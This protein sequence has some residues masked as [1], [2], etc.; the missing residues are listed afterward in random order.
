MAHHST[1]F[2]GIAS[3]LTNDLGCCCGGNSLISF[4][5]C[6]IY[7]KCDSTVVRCEVRRRGTELQPVNV[8]MSTKLED[9]IFI[10]TNPWGGTWELW[11]SCSPR[12]RMTLA[13]STFVVGYD[14]CP[15]CCSENPNAPRSVSFEIFS[16]GEEYGWPF[17]A[18]SRY[19]GT[20]IIPPNI[21]GCAGSFVI[22]N[23][24]PSLWQLCQSLGANCENQGV[25]GSVWLWINGPHAGD[26]VH[27]RFVPES[28]FSH[29]PYYRPA[30]TVR[31]YWQLREINIG[32]TVGNDQSFFPFSSYAG[33][34]IGIRQYTVYDPPI[35]SLIGGAPMTAS[36]DD[37]GYALFAGRPDGCQFKGLQSYASGNIPNV[38][39]LTV[40]TKISLQPI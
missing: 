20:H 1:K 19:S 22:N 36:V 32:W 16:P 34:S 30:Y 24:I 37:F 27:T 35:F 39:F 40:G 38:T 25:L 2:C 15:S 33:I 3:H 14:D 10:G 11:V 4:H 18:L 31:Y 12:G 7:W 8:V 21:S 17:G 5:G 9:S 6:T 29:P 23:S 13:S 28:S 26:L